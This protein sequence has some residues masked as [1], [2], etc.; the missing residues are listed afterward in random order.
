MP[1][2]YKCFF[3]DLLIYI[4]LEFCSTEKF[5]IYEKHLRAV[6]DCGPTPLTMQ[7]EN[8]IILHTNYE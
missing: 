5:R 8:L 4:S 7:S 1:K 2:T 6:P 3:V